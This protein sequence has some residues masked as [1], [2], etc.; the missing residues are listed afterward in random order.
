M[1]DQTN[2]HQ[3]AQRAHAVDELG[4]QQY[5]D[6]LWDGISKGVAKKMHDGRLTQTQLIDTINRPDAVEAVVYE[7]LPESD[8]ATWDLYRNAGPKRAARNERIEKQNRGRE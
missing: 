6:R 2:D 4:R 8:S 1:N 5:G 3:L 7:G